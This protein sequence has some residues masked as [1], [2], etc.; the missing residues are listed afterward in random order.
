MAS[1]PHIIYFLYLNALINYHQEAYK[2][3]LS[4]I[5]NVLSYE[6]NVAMYHHLHA[7]ILLEREAYV[8]A[9]RSIDIA[10]ALEPEEN[11]FLITLA[12]ITHHLGNTPI[13]CEI[14]SSV[15]SSEP[16]HTGALH[17]KSLICTSVLM[18]KGK[19]LQS[20]LFHNLLIPMEKSI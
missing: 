18:E 14:I 3:A 5:K 10:L 15:L 6:P 1:F 12:L 2:E 4:L 19:I 7:K 11:D 8:E 20:I 13:A 9:K 17:L 16:H